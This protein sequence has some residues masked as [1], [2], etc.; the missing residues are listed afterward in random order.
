MSLVRHS[1]ELASVYSWRDNPK[2]K[3]NHYRS[4]AKWAT[5]DV[6]HKLKLFT[7]RLKGFVERHQWKLVLALVLG[8]VYQ[9]VEVTASFLGL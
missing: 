6:R 4:A 3:F 7:I 1:L 2:R 8:H 5:Y 9:G